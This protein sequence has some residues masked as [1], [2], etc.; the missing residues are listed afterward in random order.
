[1]K[2]TKHKW[3][4]VDYAFKT[5]KCSKCGCE[6]YWDKILQRICFVKFGKQYY[7]TPD[8]DSFINCDN[9]LKR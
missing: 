4:K 9:N 5:W 2:I 7:Q 1:M 6:R 3:V 8:C